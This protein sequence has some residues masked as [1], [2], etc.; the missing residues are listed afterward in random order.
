ME[1]LPLFYQL[2]GKPCLLVGG[3][4]VA[5]RKA[6]L[7]TRAGARLCVVAP[8]VCPQLQALCDASGGE[9]RR[10]SYQR[11]D[12]KGVYLVVA[13]TDDRE[14]NKQ[15]YADCSERQLPVNV[16][17]C[18]DLCNFIFPAIIDRSPL[19]AAISSSGESPVLARRLRSKIESLMPAAYGS[20]ARL[21]GSYR[22]KVKAALSDAD[23][24]RDFWEH[25]L[26][27]PVT[28]VALSG[29]LEKARALLEQSLDDFDQH[30]SRG[31]VFLIG[32]GPGDPDL[33]TFKA[34]RLL[35]KADVVLYDRLVAEPILDM[36][37]KDAERIYV[38]KARKDHTLPQQEINKL[39]VDYAKQGKKVARLKGG[40]PFI[41]GRGGE[42]IELLADQQVPF[43]VVPGITAAS[44]CAAYSGIP[45]THRD[46]AQSVRFITGHLKNNSIDLPWSELAKT[47]QTLVFY[48]GLVG[49]HE[50]CAQLVRHGLSASTPIA[51][52]EKG[53]TEQQRVITG[54]LSSMPAKVA[55]M[56]VRAPT[57]LIIGEVVKLRG[58]LCWA[59]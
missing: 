9:L 52:V 27:G 55:S 1:F 33:L 44:G 41:F 39:L 36:A 30:S 56:Q 49:L 3:G 28:E 40:D 10:A 57:L 13:A 35:Q 18:P 4:V 6:Q 17:D 54:D 11:S 23:Q 5:L 26:D 32:A 46:Y 15:I 34:L 31:E 51:L 22:P 19:V 38:G 8:E 53:T 29:N 50:I 21:L 14:T 48:M 58:K 20:L 45:L 47:N 24:R 25:I 37:R 7:L 16:V 12:L 2:K 42:E 43:Q 59:G